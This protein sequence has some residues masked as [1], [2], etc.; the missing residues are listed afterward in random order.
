MDDASFGCGKCKFEMYLVAHEDIICI[1]RK[2]CKRLSIQY[3]LKQQKGDKDEY[4][5]S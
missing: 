3:M 2:T 4:F 5:Y 1:E